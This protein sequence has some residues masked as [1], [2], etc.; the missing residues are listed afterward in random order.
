MAVHYLTNGQRVTDLLGP[1]DASIS[2]SGVLSGAN[3]SARARDIDTLRI[4]GQPLDLIWNTFLYLVAIENFEAEYRNQWWIPYKIHCSVLS[5]PNVTSVG[6]ALSAAAEAVVSL[7]TMY[8]AVPTAFLPIPDTRPMLGSNGATL[9]PAQ[10]ATATASLRDS[11]LILTAEQGR[12]EKTLILAALDST[13]PTSQF[14][15]V[16]TPAVGAAEAVQYL[17]LSQD[18]MG[19]AEMFLSQ[20]SHA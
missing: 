17:A 4:M 16:F 20:G 19:Q 5:N 10:T 12:R 18:C 14:L 13:L 9:G 1:D 15:S 3:A 11:Q 6:A 7:D 8:G 2:F